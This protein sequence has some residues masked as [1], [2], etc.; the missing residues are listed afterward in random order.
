MTKQ[1]TAREVLEA[2]FLCDGG[3]EACQIPMF[4]ALMSLQHCQDEAARPK[5]I[6]KAKEARKLAGGEFNG[7][8]REFPV[9]SLEGQ[10]DAISAALDGANSDSI[11]SLGYLRAAQAVDETD[12]GRAVAILCWL[13]C[14]GTISK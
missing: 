1:E 2:L 6:A 3:N 11:T 14:G 12:S 5:V 13:A 8:A 10:G 4:E 7:K 9:L